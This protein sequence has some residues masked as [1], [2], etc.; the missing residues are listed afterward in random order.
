MKTFIRINLLFLSDDKT[1]IVD[2]NYNTRELLEQLLLRYF[3]DK[4]LVL[5]KIENIQQN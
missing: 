5:A 4:F 3:T 2:D 1:I